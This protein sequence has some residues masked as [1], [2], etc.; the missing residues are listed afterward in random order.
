MAVSGSAAALSR[1]GHCVRFAGGARQS[2]QV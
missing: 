1:S 2:A